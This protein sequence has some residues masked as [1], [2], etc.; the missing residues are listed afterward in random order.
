LYVTG[1][2]RAGAAKSA[3]P[4]Q[5]LPNGFPGIQQVDFSGAAGENENPPK[6]WPPA[7]RKECDMIRYALTL[8]LVAACG[9]GCTPT[10][11]VH[12]NTFSQFDEPLSQGQSIF[13]AVDPNSRN[14]ILGRQ[15]AAKIG[16]MLEDLGYRAA[17]QPEDARYTLTFRA[18]V[19]SSEYLSYMP[20]SR[21]YGGYYGLYGSGF[22]RG[23]GWGYTT[24]MPFIETVYTHW[25]E[26]RLYGQSDIIK[27]KTQPLWIG[28]ALVGMDDPELRQAVNFLLV[29]LME[30]FG[31]DTGRWVTTKLEK[32]DP[33]VLA[34]TGTQ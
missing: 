21:P 9:A 17:K 22:H 23:F 19:D 32:D 12:V 7:Q 29:G 28:E 5:F 11:R 13:V 33:R 1:A 25:L 30:Y 16:T 8:I 3:T 27:G 2:V 18:G 10:Y 6:A 26:A 24:Y 15:I 34:V 31:T 4:V 20:V 14:P